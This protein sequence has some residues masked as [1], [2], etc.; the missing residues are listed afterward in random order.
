MSFVLLTGAA[1]GIGGTNER[2]LKEGPCLDAIRSGGTVQS[3]DLA[4]DPRWPRWGPRVVS[5]LGV[6]GMVGHTAGRGFY[7]T[8][9]TIVL[10]YTETP[11]YTIRDM[12]PRWF[13]DFRADDRSAPAAP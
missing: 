11:Y 12:V 6:A 4:N 1:I 5:E 9:A 8:T 7:V 10:N 13:D 2:G 3:A